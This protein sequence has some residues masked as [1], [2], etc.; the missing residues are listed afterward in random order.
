MSIGSDIADIRKGNVAP[1]NV[2]LGT[3]EYLME[4]IRKAF[5]QGVLNGEEDEFNFGRFDM[6]T[7]SLGSAL[8]EAESF[9]FF[10]DQR[11]IFIDHPYFFTGEKVKNGPE[12]DVG[13]LEEYLTHPSDF[14]VVVFFAPYEKL[15]RRKKI[16]KLLKKNAHIISVQPMKEKET[17]QYIKDYLSTEQFAIQ[18]QAFEKLFQLTDGKLTRIM[19]ELDKLMV[20]RNE[21]RTIQ[22]Q[23]VKDLVPKS[24]DQNIFELNDKVLKRDAEGALELYSD[25]LLQKEEPI[26]IIALMI[27]QFRLLLQ[28]KILRKKGY[29]Q[30]EIASVLKVHPYRVKLA[31]RQ[32]RQFDQETLSR[33]H[34]GLIEAD[35][36]MKTGKVDQILQFELFILKFAEGQKKTAIK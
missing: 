4:M 2:V 6:E 19:N 16:S 21:S 29:Q 32:E 25:L 20:Y 35:Y 27:S 8:E 24:L 14:S 36:Q 26:K 18:P 30:A 5:V 23:D 9:P 33:A 28:V 34:R 7:T 3:E 22:A 15:D 11:L 31:A 17:K 12:H 13:W 1:L 10:G